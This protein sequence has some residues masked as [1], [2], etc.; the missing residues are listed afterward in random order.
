MGKKA[1]GALVAHAC[2]PIYSGGRSQEDFGSSQP[3]EIICKTLSQKNPSHTHKKGWWKK[4]KKGWW[5][6][7]VGLEFKPQ[8]HKKKKKCWMWWHVPVISATREA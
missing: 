2:N 7:G 3:G 1:R 4:K 6:V 5:S 8:Y